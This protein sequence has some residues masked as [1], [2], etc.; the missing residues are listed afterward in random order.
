MNDIIN[1]E[2]NQALIITAST[3]RIHLPDGHEADLTGEEMITTICP[4]CGGPVPLDLAVFC[5]VM[6]TGGDLY[7][8]SIYCT[9]CSKKKGKKVT[10]M[11]YYHT[12]RYCGANLD[13]GESCNCTQRR[14]A[15]PATT[16]DD[17]NRVS[18]PPTIH[19]VIIP[20]AA[21]PVKYEGRTSWHK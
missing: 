15:A 4:E 5:D 20:R 19:T 18:E 1:S 11:S 10:A 16:R 2:E 9:S 14:D 6:G 13:P 7:G 12:C 21:A 8:T 3:Y 17:V